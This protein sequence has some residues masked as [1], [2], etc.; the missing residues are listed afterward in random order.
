MQHHWTA[1]T[2]LQQPLQP[3]KPLP[4]RPTKGSI[5][6]TMASLPGL[7]SSVHRRDGMPLGGEGPPRWTPLRLAGGWLLYQIRVRLASRPTWLL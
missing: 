6:M 7:L 3:R 5:L 1:A 2:A 4:T